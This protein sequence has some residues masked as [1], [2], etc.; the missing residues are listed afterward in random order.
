MCVCVFLVQRIYI[1][2]Y[3]TLHKDSG[4]L[5]S[6]YTNKMY[7]YMTI[8]KEISINIYVCG[9]LNTEKASFSVQIYTKRISIYP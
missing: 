3:A 2:I 6:K 5:C 1:Y 7:T 4:R 9:C 8:D